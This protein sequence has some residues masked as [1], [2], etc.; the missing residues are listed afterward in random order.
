MKV[1]RDKAFDRLCKLKK[2]KISAR[3]VT[4]R[5]RHLASTKLPQSLVTKQS[6]REWIVQSADKQN[7]YSVVLD[8]EQCPTKCRILCADCKTC[9]HMYSCTCMINHTICKHI[10]LT[11]TCAAESK[12]DKPCSTPTAER[13]KTKV[14]S[15]R[16]TNKKCNSPNV[17]K[18]PC[19]D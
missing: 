6:Q 16:K 8:L 12:Q 5:R 18:N 1:S 9:I 11:A 3:L 14:S 4:I 17:V 13:V 10:H 15:K 7:Q 2:G 19:I